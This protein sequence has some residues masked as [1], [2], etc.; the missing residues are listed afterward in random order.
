MTTPTTFERIY[1]FQDP[2][3]TRWLWTADPLI[4]FTRPEYHGRLVGSHADPRTDRGTRFHLVWSDGINEWVEHFGT[5][6]LAVMRLAA[7]DDCVMTDGLFT[8]NATDF[9]AKAAVFL[10][11]CSK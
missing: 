5:F 2:T 3:D 8:D 6:A 4:E 1:G 10:E 7:L 11:G 9:A